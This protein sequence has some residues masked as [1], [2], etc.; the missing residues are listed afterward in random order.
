MSA[1]LRKGQLGRAGQVLE[2][3]HRREAAIVLSTAC[4]PMLY[5]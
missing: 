1:A 3:G 5:T 2:A 4:A